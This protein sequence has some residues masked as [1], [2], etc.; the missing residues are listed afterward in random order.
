MKKF[1]ILAAAALAGLVTLSGVAAADEG[2]FKSRAHNRAH[3]VREGF[4]RD[5]TNTGA[6]GTRSAH[7]VQTPNANGFNR[8]T[9][10]TNGKGQTAT[11]DTSGTYDAPTHTWTKT[12][13]RTNFDGSTATKTSTTT[14]TDDGFTRDSSLT[15]RKGVT[16]N[17][18]V[19]A[20]YDKEAHTMD[21][22]IS[23]TKTRPNA[24]AGE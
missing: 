15:S 22:T 6:N 4:T 3:H 1:S 16:I 24:G 8:S 21:K 10:V 19:D 17:R 14:R 7:T 23:K 13:N 2:N 20:S 5:V 18:S 11:R 9:T 12:S